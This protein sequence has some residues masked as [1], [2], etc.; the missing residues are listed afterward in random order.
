MLEAGR[1]TSFSSEDDASLDSMS[2]AG[3][4][5]DHSA[6][7]CQ[8]KGSRRVRQTE[9]PGEVPHDAKVTAAQAESALGHCQATEWDEDVL[10]QVDMDQRA[11]EEQL[12]GRVVNPELT[13]FD[14]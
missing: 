4:D 13:K 11:E 5:A 2:E 8:R 10:D 1:G 6:R 14:W 9:Q 3:D 7:L 12:V